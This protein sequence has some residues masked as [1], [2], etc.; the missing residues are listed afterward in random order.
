MW[1]YHRVMYQKDGI[2]DSVDP[3]QIAP[4]DTYTET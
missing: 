1:Y 2:A 4:S 3:D